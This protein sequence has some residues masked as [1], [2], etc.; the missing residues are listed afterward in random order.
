MAEIARGEVEILVHTT[1][2]SR[3]QDDARY[4]ALAQSYIDFQPYT[5]RRL[6]TPPEDNIEDAVGDVADVQL[7]GELQQSTQEER[8]SK[9]SY[10]PD[11]DEEESGSKHSA[12]S[13]PYQQ[14]SDRQDITDFPLSSQLSFRSVLDNGNSPALRFGTPRQETIHADAG[15]RYLQSSADS[16]GAAPS[17]VADSQPENEVKSILEASPTGILE[18][19]LRITQLDGSSPELPLHRT[20]AAVELLGAAAVVE[21]V[22]GSEDMGVQSSPSPQKRSQQGYAEA[23][24]SR[25]PLLAPRIGPLLSEVQEAIML[26]KRKHA[27]STADYGSSPSNVPSSIMMAPRSTS[28]RQVRSSKRQRIEVASSQLSTYKKVTKI[29]MPL[30]PASSMISNAESSDWADLLEIRPALPPTSSGIL[31]ADMLITDSLRS[32]KTKISSRGQYPYVPQSQTRELRNMERG[33]W[34]ADSGKWDVGIRN[35]CWNYLGKYVG[36][37]MAGWGVSCVRDAE[38]SWIRI[39]CWGIV[40]EHIYLLL[41]MASTSKIKGTGACWIGGDG[42]TIIQMPL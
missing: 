17:T 10:H 28:E 11:D 9:A 35:R 40:V 13:T 32:L 42:T 15:K 14:S 3:G 18:S 41:H 8:E 30:D 29:N 21:L 7:Q 4:R 23:E 33:Y 24:A 37:D 39:Y 25:G 31:T 6:D 36:M 5:R 38:T 34:L 26:T 1:A 22:E 16:W 20:R 27:D 19:Y 12:R 2:P